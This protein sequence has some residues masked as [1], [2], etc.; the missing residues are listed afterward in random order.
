MAAPARLYV[1]EAGEPI[2]GIMAEF[3]TPADIYHAAEAVRDAGYSKWD[4]FTPFPIHGMEEAMG[5]KRTVL[6]LLV[7]MGAFTGV[8]LAYLMQWWMSSADY[9][10]VVQG[11]PYGSLITGGWQPF[12]PI[13]FELGIL[14]AA[15]SSLIAMLALNGLP[16]WHHPLF[17]KERFLS[18]AEDR[19]FVCIEAGDPNF[20]PEKTRALLEEA[21]A[22]SIELVEE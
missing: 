12:V 22:T 21:G 16:R 10:M 3:G 15:F 13:T 17:K 8:G 4:T 18:S 5:V 1:T 9:Q 14:F 2:H 20:D 11:K 19:F 7:A 6:P